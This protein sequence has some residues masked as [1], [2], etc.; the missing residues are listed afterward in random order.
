MT[1]PWLFLAFLSLLL[2]LGTNASQLLARLDRVAGGPV[3]VRATAPI[4]YEL[5]VL[6]GAFV[7][8]AAMS[9]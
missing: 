8:L 1:G 5:L 7:F 6:S 4:A 9:L 2:F 3:T